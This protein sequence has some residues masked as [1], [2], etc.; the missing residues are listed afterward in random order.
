METK[1]ENNNKKALKI[2]LNLVR[3]LSSAKN[4]TTESGI[5]RGNKCLP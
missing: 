1:K 3:I 2:L 5:K 4:N